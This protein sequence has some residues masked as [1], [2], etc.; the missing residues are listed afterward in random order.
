MNKLAKALLQHYSP[1]KDLKEIDPSHAG[2]GV[3]RSR[4]VSAHPISYF[5][6]EG[7]V[8]ESVVTEQGPHQYSVNLPEGFPIYDIGTDPEKHIEN[9]H[10]ESMNRST[11]PG[12]LHND[13]IH[14][15]LKEHGYKG[16][17]HTG[18]PTHKGIVGL[19]EKQ[20][21]MQKS[22]RPLDRILSETRQRLSRL[23]YHQEQ[24]PKSALYPMRGK[25]NGNR[26]LISPDLKQEGKWRKTHFWPGNDPTGHIEGLTY[27][28]AVKH[29]HE[30]GADLENPIPDF[31]KSQKPMQGLAKAL[32]EKAQ[33]VDFNQYGFS[34]HNE[35]GI[36]F[37]NVH[38]KLP[39][40]GGD[41]I[42]EFQFATD[43]P[44]APDKLYPLLADVEPAHRN[45]GL[46]SEA[47]KM[48]EEKSGKKIVP[49]HSQTSSAKKLWAQPNRPFGKSELQKG[50]WQRK[51]KFNPLKDQPPG[52][53]LGLIHSW[54]GGARDMFRQGIKKDTGTAR[55]RFLR[56]LSAKTKTRH[57]KQGGR[58]FL[59]HRGHGINEPIVETDTHVQHKDNSSWTPHAGIAENFWDSAPEPTEK[60]TS[61]WIHENNILSVPKQY[62]NVPS[63][64]VTRRE[65]PFS[66]EHEVIV[67]PHTSEKANYVPR[68]DTDVI[69]DLNE[70][71]QARGK[72]HFDQHHQSPKA[73]LNQ[74][75]SGLTNFGKSLAKST[76]L[77]KSI[78]EG[79]RQNKT[80]KTPGIH[81]S[82]PE[83]GA[84]SILK[85]PKGHFEVKHNS[86]QPQQD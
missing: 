64:A 28:E 59:L 78:P 66:I 9:L 53:Q 42:G 20:S 57:G 41:H 85:H 61:A 5:Y 65:N 25:D 70:R 52:H 7:A 23:K 60:P 47:Y 77:N 82:H 2:K 62:G 55:D 48:A 19:Y 84:V 81:F 11:N 63:G 46:A 75:K 58:E 8:P 26:I 49:S 4:N 72:G 14:S 6:K 18:H 3:D 56:Q 30:G 45:K 35:G 22:E 37:V 68:S 40:G 33:P 54:Q 16:F 51:N 71:I 29:A 34:H 39:H 13:E 38:H 21:V 31:D 43:H 17:E 1:Q 67:G 27:P 36:H 73:V 15:R 69:P 12:V 50:S 44:S 32:L 24:S 83:H 79:W 74:R 86:Q 80:S 10:N 76:S